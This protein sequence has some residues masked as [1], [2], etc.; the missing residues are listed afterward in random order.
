MPMID[1]YAK[2]GTFTDTKKLA[3]DAAATVKKN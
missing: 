3:T 1:I 2:V